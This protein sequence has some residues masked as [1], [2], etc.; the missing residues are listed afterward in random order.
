MTLDGLG[1]G[2][3]QPTVRQQLAFADNACGALFDNV[4]FKGAGQDISTAVNYVA[5]SQALKTRLQKTGAWLQSVGKSA[6]MLEADFQKRV[7]AVSLDSFIN[8]EGQCERLFIG[9]AAHQTTATLARGAAN[10]PP[11]VGANTVLTQLAA[12]DTLVISGRPYLC[13]TA[14]TNDAGAAMVLVPTPADFGPTADA[15][16]LKNVRRDGGQR[17]KVFAMWQPPVGIFDHD[18][19]LGAGNEE[20]V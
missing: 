14:P 6:Y 20:L 3:L 15:Y 5:Q 16:I 12:G 18:G 13:S 9:D 8:P 2:G 7:N 4:Y 1:V 11:Y 10:N 19:V 17:N